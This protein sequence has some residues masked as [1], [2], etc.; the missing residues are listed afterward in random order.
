LEIEHQ[1]I[2]NQ[3]KK[4]KGNSDSIIHWISKQ[5]I[6]DL[7]EVAFLLNYHKLS[8]EICE[9]LNS[10][11]VDNSIDSD[12]EEVELNNYSLPEKE[13]IEEKFPKETSQETKKI[14]SSYPE[15]HIQFAINKEYE[16]AI[17]NCNSEKKIEEVAAIQLL[18]G[19]FEKANELEKT[20]K[21]D[22]G[23]KYLKLI[24]AFELNRYEFHIKSEMLFRELIEK[25]ESYFHIELILA[26][27]SRRPWIGYPFRE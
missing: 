22:I 20:I 16:K 9:Y 12:R 8:K 10:I 5:Y 2:E 6:E 3:F 11:K 7:S 19:E 18:L 27:K 14:I 23:K 24:K 17:R 21:D 15:R 26:L 13:K 1:L 4:W 25:D